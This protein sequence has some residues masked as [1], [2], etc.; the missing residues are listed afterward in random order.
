M[1]QKQSAIFE[2]YLVSGE[3][4][5]INLTHVVIVRLIKPEA[6]GLNPGGPIKLRISM[7]NGE[8]H[9]IGNDIADNFLFALRD[10]N[11]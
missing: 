4:T 8:H 3:K 9:D 1:S 5:W 7:V 6:L 11:S 2:T 10:F